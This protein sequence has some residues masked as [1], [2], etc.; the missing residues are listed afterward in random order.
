MSAIENGTSNSM[1]SVFE[2]LYDYREAVIKIKVE[3]LLY[4]EIRLSNK[5]LYSLRNQN[6]PVIEY[7]LT[8]S[9]LTN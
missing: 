6:Y 4:D 2:H 7:S 9:T 8:I 5:V 1:S 3:S